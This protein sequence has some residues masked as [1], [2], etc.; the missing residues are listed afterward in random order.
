MYS[1]SACKYFDIFSSRW[2]GRQSTR[3]DWGSC[4]LVGVTKRLRYILLP[5]SPAWLGDLCA[6][7]YCLDLGHARL[8]R[9]WCRGQIQ[10]GK[11]GPPVLFDVSEVHVKYENSDSGRSFFLVR[12]VPVVAMQRARPAVLVD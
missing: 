3:F 9:L 12:Y 7:L 11:V 1:R 8:A 2:H 10:T 6:D 4:N 5:S